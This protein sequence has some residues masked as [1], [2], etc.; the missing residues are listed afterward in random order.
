MRAEARGRKGARAIRGLPVLLLGA[1]AAVLIGAPGAAAGGS[2]SVL[3]ASP[4]SARTASLYT[5]DRRYEELETL[6]GSA[7]RGDRDRPPGLGLAA[8]RQINVTW[9]VHDVRPWRVDRVY[10]MPTVS[11]P[12]D[13]AIWIHSTTKMDSLTGRWH[14]AENP[15]AL[16]ALLHDLNVLGQASEDS[17]GAVAPPPQRPERPEGPAAARPADGDTGWRWAIPS[18]A[19]GAAMGAAAV[20]RLRRGEPKETAPRQE[21][22]DA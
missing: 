10:A 3:M 14:K 20:W 2:T 1:L 7:D 5:S 22:L 17:R 19:A 8:T 13:R 4:E 6:L 11:K 16:R 18:A 9:L 12:A 15:R 21:L